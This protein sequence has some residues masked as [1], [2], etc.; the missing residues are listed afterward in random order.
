[1]NKIIEK[2]N[3]DWVKVSLAIFIVIIIVNF[4]N[5]FVNFIPNVN[6]RYLELGFFYTPNDIYNLAQ[7]YGEVGRSIYITCALTID[8]LVPLATSAFLTILVIYL[9]KKLNKHNDNKIIILGIL[10]CL[11]DWIENILLIITLKLY[12]QEYPLLVTSASIMTTIKYILMIYFVIVLIYRIYKV[13][14]AIK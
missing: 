7:N 12:P 14:K 8:I 6:G 5:Y 4:L 10:A 3:K 11:S 1:M 2:I 9:G 13:R